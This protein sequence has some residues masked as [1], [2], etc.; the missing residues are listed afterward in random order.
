MALRD[1]WHTALV[2]FG[3]AEDDRYVDDDE[4]FDDVEPEAE[5]E[6]RY[7]DREQVR[8]VAPAGATRSTTSSPTSPAAPDARAALGRQ[9][10]RR[11]TRCAS[12]S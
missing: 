6:E 12:T 5:L 7:R 1:T 10:P 3:L 9:R 2:Y 4:Q 11:R 8:R